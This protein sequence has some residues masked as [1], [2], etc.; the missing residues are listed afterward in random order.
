[1][2]DSSYILTEIWKARSSWLELSKEERT[3]VFDD[4]FNPLLMQ[5]VG[6]GTEIIACALNDNSGNERIDYQFMAIW[7]FPNKEASE[8]LENAAKEAG[9]LNYFE[10][11][12]FSGT[13]IGPPQLN[14]A[15]IHL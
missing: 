6:N 8:K 15:M 14:D 5:F 2:G 12:N 1:M 7:K 4:I 3:R 10:Q 11:V 13:I 9:F